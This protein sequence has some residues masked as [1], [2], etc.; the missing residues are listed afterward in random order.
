MD[1]NQSFIFVETLFSNFLYEHTRK[2]FIDEIYI[3]CK[4]EEARIIKIFA[5]N[6]HRE[7]PHISFKDIFIALFTIY[8][9]TNPT[10]LTSDY[11]TISIDF[12]SRYAD[13]RDATI[14]IYHKINNG[15]IGGLFVTSL[16][17]LHH[18]D[19]GFFYPNL[20]AGRRKKTR[21]RTHRK[22]NFRKRAYSRRIR[23]Y[24]YKN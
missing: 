9:K 4:A 14:A 6:Y 19:E 1:S 5:E 17:D 13:N 20:R 18:P 21:R 24:K 7:K 16:H 22:S 10:N 12:F 15:E 8:Y 2:E 3:C 23:K 11:P